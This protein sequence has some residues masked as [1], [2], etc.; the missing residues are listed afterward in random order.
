MALP[1]LIY[2][3]HRQK[4]LSLRHLNWIQTCKD[5]GF[6][7]YIV[8]NNRSR[9]RIEKICKQ[10]QCQG[11]YFA[12]KPMTLT[13]NDLV[14]FYDLDV[15]TSIVVGDQVLTDIVMGKW[16]NAYSI[17]VNP[18]DLN[19]SFIKRIQ[20]KFEAFLLKKTQ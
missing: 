15:K 6:T 2:R 10:V 3:Q 11:F 8:S 14:H 17:L 16:I 13:I 12:C 4:K 1:Q 5:M 18:V 7:I 19:C 9:K 20:Y